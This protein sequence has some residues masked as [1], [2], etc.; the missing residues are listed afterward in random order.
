VS[1]NHL[2]AMLRHYLTAGQVPNAERYSPTS[3]RSGCASIAADQQV[4]EAVIE[5]HLRWTHGMVSVYTDHRA[6]NQ[7]T[8]SRAIHQAYL[9]GSTEPYDSYDDECYVCERPG[10]LLLCDGA[11]CIRAAHPK[12][13]GLDTAPT[14]DW[15][16]DPCRCAARKY[17][18]HR[19]PTCT[20]LPQQ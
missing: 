4:T 8:V 6:A 19:V 3:L 7:L 14:G 20:N 15:L 11:H 17:R 9:A 5:E 2:A 18:H 12:C 16:C 10:M 13:V 1:R